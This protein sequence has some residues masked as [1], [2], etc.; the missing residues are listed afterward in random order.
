VGQSSEVKE[1]KRVG[2]EEEDEEQDF[3]EFAHLHRRLRVSQEEADE[4][5]DRMAKEV[6]KTKLTKLNSLSRHYLK[7]QNKYVQK[8]MF[9]NR[10]EALAKIV[11]EHAAG[12]VF[13]P[14]ELEQI[15]YEDAL[16]AI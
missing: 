5:F 9:K 3:I 7:I 6:V 12:E 8:I 4:I 16:E 2:F 11:Q 10:P 13:V 14:S 15:M 1:K